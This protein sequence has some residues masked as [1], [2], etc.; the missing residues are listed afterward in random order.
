MQS[1]W[2]HAG[3][4]LQCVPQTC[5]LPDRASA[6]AW[7]AQA[8]QGKLCCWTFSRT[9]RKSQQALLCYEELYHKETPRNSRAGSTPEGHWRIVLPRKLLT[10]VHSSHLTATPREQLLHLQTQTSDVCHKE[11]SP[12]IYH[13]KPG[14]LPCPPTINCDTST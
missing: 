14:C 7:I 10:G 3:C 12:V 2:D 4:Q 11:L 8:L 9:T 1:E 5:S 13:A 6:L